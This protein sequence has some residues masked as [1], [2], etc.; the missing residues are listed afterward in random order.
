MD[1]LELF[2]HWELKEG[3]FQINSVSFI[4]KLD[5]EIL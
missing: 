3:L 2:I 5:S 1:E 4:M